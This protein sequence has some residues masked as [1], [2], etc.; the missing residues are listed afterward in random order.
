MADCIRLGVI[1]CGNAFRQLH[2]PAL[3]ACADVRMVAAC[4]SVPERAKETGA[5]RIF[6]DYRELLAL[7]DVDAVDICMP[8]FLHKTMI[9]EALR[10]GKHVFCEKPDARSAEE[11]EEIAKAAHASGRVL[12]VMRNNRFLETSQFL[13]AQVD[14]GAMGKIYLARCGWIRRRGIPG[15]GGWITTKAKAG[16][17]PLIDLGIHMI[18]LAVW[19]MGNPR[20]VTATGV[21]YREFADNMATPDSRHAGFGERVENG[22]FDVEDLAAGFVR[23][24][25]GACLQVECSWASNIKRE[26][27]Y[28]NLLGNRAGAEWRDN[29]LEIFSQV[30]DR[31]VDIAPRFVNRE[32]GHGANLRHFFDVLQGKAEPEYSVEQGLNV[33]RII[34]G[35]Y[36][37]AAQGK[38][39]SL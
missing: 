7:P 13:K 22:V 9:V 23:F 31:V 2:L 36:R 10:A 14:A 5:P 24:D 33:M 1:G 18:D 39:V 25:N 28:V 6:R 15:R 26:T 16:G 21:A 30:G 32:E 35:I 38:E 37:S 8:T 19:L 17:G 27:R 11:M 34:D 12:M 20:P 3:T 29:S 4:D